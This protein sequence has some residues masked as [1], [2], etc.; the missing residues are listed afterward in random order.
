MLSKFATG[1]PEP[2]RRK[3]HTL[4]EFLE[5]VWFGDIDMVKA[6]LA[7]PQA[8]RFLETTDPGTGMTALHIAVGRNNL[9]LVHELVEAGAAFVP[10]NEGRMPSLIAILC[11]T[12]E[13]LQ[14]YITE[15]EQQARR[16]TDNV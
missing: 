6:L 9:P 5:S 7:S 12:G 15:A 3:Y 16:S 4:P 1:A 8:L 14:D 13:E 10:D 11:E 2:D